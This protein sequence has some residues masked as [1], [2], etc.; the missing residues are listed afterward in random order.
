[1]NTV[2]REECC[3]W[4]PPLA[5]Y[6]HWDV[7][8]FPA[9]SQRTKS[10]QSILYRMQMH[11]CG[12]LWEIDIRRQ[13][14]GNCHRK[15]ARGLPS[16]HS[17]EIV[18]IA[19]DREDMNIQITMRTMRPVTPGGLLAVTRPLM[20]MIMVCTRGSVT[21]SRHLLISRLGPALYTGH[22]PII[23]STGS[24]RGPDTALSGYYAKYNNLYI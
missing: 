19:T 20:I 23:T 24:S 9:K 4:S 5:L 13:D 12:L 17:D 16:H 22:R 7:F 14:D 1:M 18:D 3:Y 6:R 8:G 10:L 21:S 11:Q 2:Y 15:K